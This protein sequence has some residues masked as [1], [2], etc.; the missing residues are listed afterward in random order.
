MAST[1]TAD[2]AKTTAPAYQGGGKMACVAFGT[3][4]ISASLVVNDVIQMVRLPKG[5]VITGVTLGT[6]DLDTGGSPAIV[7]DVGDGGDTDRYI[8]GATVGQAGGITSSMMM[9]GFGHALTAED[10]I[11]VLVQVAPAT[12]ATSGT[13]SLAVTYYT[14]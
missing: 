1:F 9:T 14:P 2:A 13:V 10:T 8:D 4:E 3:Y 5:A 11:D 12:G 7:L 6:D